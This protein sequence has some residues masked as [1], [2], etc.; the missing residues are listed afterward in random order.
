MIT[1][2]DLMYDNDH[3]VW[4]LSSRR[5][6]PFRCVTPPTEIHMSNVQHITI[7]DRG[8]LFAEA[9]IHSQPDLVDAHLRVEAGHI[10][11]SARS[12]LVDAILELP[13]VPP[14][15]RLEIT[16]P[17]GEGEMLNRSGIAAATSTPGSPA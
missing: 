12:R 3:I 7:E 8:H 15:T 14:G 16:L 2:E 1:L 13:N 9:V 17:T 4:F 11:P 10:P 5:F 6:S